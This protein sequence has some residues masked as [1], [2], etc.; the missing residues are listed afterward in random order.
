MYTV[1][2]IQ[3]SPLRVQ[4]KKKATELRNA[5]YST[6]NWNLTK[7]N[8]GFRLEGDNKDFGRFSKQDYNTLL[9]L[10]TTGNTNNDYSN[11]R[12]TTSPSHVEVLG[13]TDS[14]SE[15][16]WT[17]NDLLCG[18]NRLQV[19]SEPTRR[20]STLETLLGEAQPTGEN[21]SLSTH[22]ELSI[23]ERLELYDR[24]L[25]NKRA[26]GEQLERSECSLTKQLGQII[27][28]QS[29][30]A[31]DQCEIALGQ[32]AIREEQQ[33]IGAGIADLNRGIAEQRDAIE[34]AL[35][36]RGLTPIIN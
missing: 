1:L 30:I 9:T 25:K 10:T 11:N 2:I 31:R 24:H 15:P 27:V 17:Q 14:G 22:R 19:S 26:K 8:I 13:Q 18:F 7:A 34:A 28:G 16:E 21:G 33:R 6:E 35:K 3:D 29:D 32:R 4:S 23:E 20:Y 12:E 5:F 36:Q